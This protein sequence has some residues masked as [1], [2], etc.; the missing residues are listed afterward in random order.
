MNTKFTD[1]PIN[2]C[3]EKGYCHFDGDVVIVKPKIT[4]NDILEK[5]LDVLR[6]DGYELCNLHTTVFA[7]RRKNK[8]G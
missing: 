4:P 1:E 5:L 6:K 7:Y 2:Y 8:N 3:I